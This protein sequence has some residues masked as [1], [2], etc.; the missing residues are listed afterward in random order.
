MHHEAEREVIKDLS[1]LPY[2]SGRND[3]ICAHWGQTIVSFTVTE[4]K[5]NSD[6]WI[7]FS[8]LL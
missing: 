4:L 5:N 8:D 2:F 3:P 7:I 1:K 6:R